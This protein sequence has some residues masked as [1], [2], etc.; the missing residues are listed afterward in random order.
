MSLN[1]ARLWMTV[2]GLLGWLA[3]PD[4]Y[5]Q[6]TGRLLLDLSPAGNTSYVLDGKYRMTDRQ[7]D[8]MEGPHR[9]VFWAPERRMLDTTITV[10]GGR[11][12]EVSIALRYSEEYL[13]WRKRN[14]RGRVERAWARYAPPIA[15][16]A[17][18]GWAIASYVEQ[19]QAYD[20]LSALESEYA[21][22]LDPGRIADI[23]ADAIPDA[24]DALDRARTGL[25]VS[26]GVFALATAATI[27]FRL[28]SR[29]RVPEPF[30]DKERL[31]FEG[32]VWSPSPHGTVWG[33]S[34]SM[35]LHR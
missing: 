3:I 13:T 20:D 24:K 25:V 31:R 16:L 17:G 18:A 35:P 32:L 23:K 10:L 33:A 27:Y 7:L 11:S 26:G 30:E 4:L 15:M 8:L 22:S 2:A 5:A 14:E 28:R 21:A 9:F 12:L 1:A 6:T 34:L 29:D 19:E